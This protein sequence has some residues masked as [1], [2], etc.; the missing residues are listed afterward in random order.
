MTRCERKGHYWYK[1]RRVLDKDYTIYAVERCAVCF[2]Y[3]THDDANVETPN[4][5]F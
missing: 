2:A 1:I 4:W 3:R 5:G